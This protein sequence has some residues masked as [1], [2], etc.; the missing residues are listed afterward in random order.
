MKQENI[1]NF[2]ENYKRGTYTKLIKEKDN[3]NGYKKVTAVVVRFINYYHIKS[4]KEKT[5]GKAIKNRDYE[6]Q[7]IP[8]IL[9]LNKNTNN[10]LLCAYTTN[11]HKPHAVYYYNDEIISADEYYKNSGDK[12]NENKIGLVYTLKISDIVQIGC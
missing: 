5:S 10:V 3:K 12:L 11:K 2:F 8:H 1:I 7:I 9:K 4:V 6:L